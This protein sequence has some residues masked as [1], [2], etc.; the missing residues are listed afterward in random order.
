MEPRNKEELVQAR[1]ALRRELATLAHTGGHVGQFGPLPI[2][3]KLKK[4]IADLTAL[5]ESEN[6][7]DP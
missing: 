2:V 5:L 1:E 6:S 4:Q 7:A 3:V